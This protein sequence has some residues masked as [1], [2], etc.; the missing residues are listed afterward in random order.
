MQDPTSNSGRLTHVDE[1]GQAHM[2]DVGTKEDSRRIA[3]ASST[4]SMS[5]EAAQA[6]RENTLK[7]GDC[8][9]VARI[10]AIQAV[11]QTSTLIPLCHPLRIDAVH[12]EH[13]W[14]GECKLEWRVE[15]RT[16]GPTGVEMEALTGASIAALTVYDMCKAVDRSMVIDRIMLHEKSGGTRGDFKRSE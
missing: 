16:V 15:V 4:I 14:V 13:A 3:V 1:Q 7:K 5:Q 9:S 10:A 12:V 6:I 2:V 8:I 11:K